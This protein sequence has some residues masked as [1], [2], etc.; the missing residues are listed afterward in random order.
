[1][2]HKLF[3]RE[4]ERWG[5][6]L[7][8]LV[9][10]TTLVTNIILSDTREKFMRNTDIT[11]FN[12]KMW[13]FA[14]YA[15]VFFFSFSIFFRSIILKWLWSSICAFGASW[16][17][18]LSAAAS[19]FHPLT[20]VSSHLMFHLKKLAHQNVSLQKKLSPL[21][22]NLNFFWLTKMFYNSCV[23]LHPIMFWLAQCF[24]TKMF[25]RLPCV[26]SHHLSCTKTSSWSWRMRYGR[27]SGDK[28]KSQLGWQGW[29]G[30]EGQGPA[31]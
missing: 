15:Y 20:N 30:W 6:P 25:R 7:N 4:L 12:D 14:H 11:Q 24:I 16:Q 29:L 21:N 13:T 18:S 19:H 1:M 17:V 22:F 31:F 23:Q 28:A 27:K 2:W 10:I 8:H 3:R 9:T 5:L 26:S